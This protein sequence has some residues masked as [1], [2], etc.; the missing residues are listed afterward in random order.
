MKKLL[1]L[2]LTLTLA[3]MAGLILTAR[4]SDDAE[5]FEFPQ[6]T[7]QPTDQGAFEGG[8]ATFSVQATNGNI[9]FQWQRNGVVL[10]GQT[11]STLAIEN[12]GIND[13]GLYS[14]NVAKI[15]GEAVPTRAASLSVSAL[16]GDTIVVF[17][18]PR[19]SGG[20]QGTCPGMYAGYVNFTKTIAQGWGWAPST[21]TTTIF[22]ASDGGGRTDTK[23]AYGGKYGD[24]GC[25]LTTVTVPNPPFSPKYRFTIYFPNNVPTTNYP[26]VLTGF[27]P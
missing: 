8:A 16:F 15:D 21:N 4:G 11:N 2:T 22:T 6:I 14:C 18:L 9:S 27:D 20:T 10:E 7:A 12:V 13:V 23:I 24:T 26:I 1:T 17:G 3:G 5:Q 19:V 25:N